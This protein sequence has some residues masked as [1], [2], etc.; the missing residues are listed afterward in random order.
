MKIKYNNR[1]GCFTIC[2]KKDKYQ[3]DKYFLDYGNVTIGNNGLSISGG[4][5]ASSEY[6]WNL[7]GGSI[8]FDVNLSNVNDLVNATGYLVFP[9]NK[10]SYYCDITYPA[11][12]PPCSSCL[13]IDILETNGK[14]AISTTWHTY[15]STNKVEKCQTSD[16]FKKN[17]INCS[18]CNCSQD[19]CYQP[20]YLNNN[21]Y[22]TSKCSLNGA[23]DGS[24]INYKKPF[25]LYTTFTDECEMTTYIIQNNTKLKI[26][27]NKEYYLSSGPHP[28]NHDQKRLKNVMQQ[29]GAVFVMSQWQGWSPFSNYCSNQPKGDINTSKYTVSNIKY[30]GIKVQKIR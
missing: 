17:D 20:I 5:R 9:H 6:S 26:F 24:I 22:K 13:E 12:G 29:Y 11:Y 3:Y 7:L 14:N 4:G 28:N 21:W 30:V 19:G 27:N 1:T 23:I 8:S 18:D 15:N 25:T 2:E 10:D 16:S